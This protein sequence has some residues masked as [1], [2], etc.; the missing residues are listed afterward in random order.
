[1]L[2]KLCNFIVFLILF[3]KR[4]VYY[5]EQLYFSVAGE[6]LVRAMLSV[7]IKRVAQAYKNR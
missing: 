3:V 1:M 4:L 7:R 2:I 6:T 5:F